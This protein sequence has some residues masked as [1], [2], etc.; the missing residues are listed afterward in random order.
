MARS[1]A[2]VRLTSPAFEAG[3]AIPTRYTGD[4][5]DESPPLAWG[6]VPAGTQSLALVCEDPDAPRGLFTHWLL[7][8]LPAATRELAAGVPAT[9][10]LADGSAQGRTSFRT[11]G[12][13]GPAPPPGKP[14]R[15]VFRLFAL[16]ARLDLPPGAT[17]DEL[18]AATAGHV[19]GEG[20]LI[21]T[22][23]RAK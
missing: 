8:N 7:Y 20:E 3:A 16:D 12:Y 11:V 14:H 19:L 6:E 10:T 1:V 13:G 2:A 5:Q 22:Y 4:G 9:A 18:L 17:R 15:Y 21:G 23:G